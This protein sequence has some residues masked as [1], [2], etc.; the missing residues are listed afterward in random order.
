MLNMK[1]NMSSSRAVIILNS[2]QKSLFS[3]DYI[4][5]LY[6]CSEIGNLIMDWYSC[7]IFF[8]FFLATI[9]EKGNNL[10]NFFFDSL[11]NK[12]LSKRGLLIKKRIYS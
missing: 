6:L 9:F 3:K 8:F 5:H 11:D 10:C 1:S 2:V 7:K 4:L 12:T